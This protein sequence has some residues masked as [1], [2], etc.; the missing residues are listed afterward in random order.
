MRQL[1][2]L[3]KP[4][5]G[6][7]M[8]WNAFALSLLF[9]AITR[10]IPGLSWTAAVGDAHALDLGVVTRLQENPMF[11]GISEELP[12]LLGPRTMIRYLLLAVGSLIGSWPAAGVWI[13][14]VAT[15]ATIA[16]VIRLAHTVLPL[17]EYTL[18]CGVAAAGLGAF[19][20]GWSADPAVAVGSALLI[21]SLY[22][23]LSM[24]ENGTPHRV[25]ISALLIGLAAYIRIEMMLIAVPMILYLALV[26]FVHPT[27]RV[28]QLPRPAMALSLFFMLALM[29]WP[30]V[31]QNMVQTGSSPILPGY[32]A[33]QISGA[34]GMPGAVPLGGQFLLA[35]KTLALDPQGLGLVFGVLWV[36]GLVYLHLWEVK[37]QTAPWAW[38]V[39]P[40]FWLLSLLFTSPMLGN[41]GF[42][43]TLRMGAP[44]LLPLA[45]YVPGKLTYELLQ[46]N[47][48]AD[49]RRYV[50]WLACCAGGYLLALL[51]GLFLAQRGS[52]P[53]A[54]TSETA[55]IQAFEERPALRN[56]R[57]ATD[58]PGLFLQAGKREVFGLRGETDW[59][60]FTLKNADGRLDPERTA[61]FMRRENIR[62]L[63][64][65]SLDH[66]LASALAAL[67]NPP[68]MVQI[69][70]TAPHRVFAL[71][72]PEAAERN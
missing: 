68:E 44:M 22:F 57:L 27:P 30:M 47:T 34:P 40:V 45:L 55:L 66:P 52:D 39:I 61:A 28:K 14:L 65:S 4:F 24:F 18:L 11:Y 32:D 31:D 67:P 10:F 46:K 50:Y 48:F 62:L 54:V 35:L 33:Q 23:Y 58:R 42:Q 25:L 20:F 38:A 15:V 21:W 71:R 72:W 37:R 6:H 41:E 69:P 13:S 56:E 70:T 19:H 26:G 63:H 51:P 36:I 43:E 53:F 8:F 16:G 17:R 60:I 9:F 12:L 1:Q 5:A 64:L 59:R 3:C 49:D 29:L 7:P 2:L